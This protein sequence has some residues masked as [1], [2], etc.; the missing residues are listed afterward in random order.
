MTTN[1]RGFLGRILGL[2][3]GTLSVSAYAL[4]SLQP[5]KWDEESDIV[6]LGAG[7]GGLAAAVTC[8]ANK[9]PFKI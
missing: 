6:I 3:G 4:P 7:G 2:A 5:Q 1:R 8:V 9:I